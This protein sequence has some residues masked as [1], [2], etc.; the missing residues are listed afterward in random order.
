[1]RHEVQ[2]LSLKCLYILR[3]KLHQSHDGQQAE[4]LTQKASH[5]EK[6]E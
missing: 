5:E 1:M 2:N 6:A 4:K 3:W